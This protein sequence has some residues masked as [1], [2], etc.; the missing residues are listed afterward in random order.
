MVEV[1]VAELPLQRLQR[2]QRFRGSVAENAEEAA[3][4]EVA[5]AVNADDAKYLQLAKSVAVQCSVRRL[6]RCQSLMALS[7]LDGSR[8]RRRHRES[9]MA[10]SSLFRCDCFLMPVRKPYFLCRARF[11]LIEWVSRFMRDFY[12]G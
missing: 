1:A 9:L 10:W 11:M 8:R 3:V 5:D 4:A 2:L 6:C 7:N 12:A